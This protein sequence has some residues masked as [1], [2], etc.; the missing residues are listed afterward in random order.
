MTSLRSITFYTAP[1][2][3]Q[4]H[5]CM[6]PSKLTRAREY[7]HVYGHS[8]HKN[9]HFNHTTV[10]YQH[11][12]TIFCLFFLVAKVC[13]DNKHENSARNILCWSS[14]KVFIKFV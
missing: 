13:P 9:L 8:N 2:L 11:K 4:S 6:F 3:I 7:A 1:Q 12:D 5:V 10:T 14:Q